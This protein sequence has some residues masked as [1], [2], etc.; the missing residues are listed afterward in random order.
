VK[1]PGAAR[2][3][4]GI[5]K[6]RTDL[7]MARMDYRSYFWCKGEDDLFIH[8]TNEYVEHP[9][10]EKRYWSLLE[11]QEGT[12][13][14]QGKFRAIREMAAKR[15]IQS[16]V[17]VVTA[18]PKETVPEVEPEKDDDKKVELTPEDEDKEKE[19]LVKK[20]EAAGPADPDAGAEIDVKEARKACKQGVDGHPIQEID[21]ITNKTSDAWTACVE[22]VQ[23]NGGDK[24]ALKEMLNAATDTEKDEGENDKDVLAV[25]GKVLGE[26]KAE[27]RA[28][29]KGR[30][31]SYAPILEVC[32]MGVANECSSGKGYVEVASFPAGV[33]DKKEWNTIKVVLPVKSGDRVQLRIRQKKTHCDCCDDFGIDSLQFLKASE[34]CEPGA[35]NS[36]A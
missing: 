34:K 1:L 18:L 6:L 11:A 5:N 26:V 4:R 2:Y 32:S 15:A 25:D 7:P 12:R 31:D 10:N 27:E 33:F 8:S 17:P 21:P 16:S 36:E 23:V 19:K 20:A 22:D 24:A 28:A 29:V 35:V 3:A 14:G 30:D 9:K 13:H